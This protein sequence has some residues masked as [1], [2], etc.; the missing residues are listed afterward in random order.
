MGEIHMV[1]LGPGDEGSV[2]M[3]SRVLLGSP[4]DNAS[5]GKMWIAKIDITLVNSYLL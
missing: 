5:F 1:G 3:A 2:V 4:L